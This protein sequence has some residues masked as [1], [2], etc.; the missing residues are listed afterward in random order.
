MNVR[1]KW[2]DKS[3]N[4]ITYIVYLMTDT[5]IQELTAI[6]LKQEILKNE[7]KR[8]YAHGTSNSKQAIICNNIDEI[9]LLIDQEI[10]ALVKYKKG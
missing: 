8:K 4:K 2:L 5:E 7:Y 3:L 9:E 6:K 1:E 10:A